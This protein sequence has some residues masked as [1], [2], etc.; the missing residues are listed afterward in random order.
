LLSPAHAERVRR[1]IEEHEPGLMRILTM[2]KG[3]DGLC[4]VLREEV[5]AA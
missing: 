3:D 2:G 1:R 5:T 4:A